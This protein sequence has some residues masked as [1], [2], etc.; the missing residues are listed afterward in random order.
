VSLA[1]GWLFLTGLGCRD[2]L[3][4]ME[5]DNR[6]PYTIRLVLNGVSQRGTYPPSK[7]TMRHS[8][9]VFLDGGIQ[10]E[11]RKEPGGTV[12]FSRYYTGEPLNAAHDEGRFTVVVVDESKPTG[13][14]GDSRRRSRTT[15][16]TT[17]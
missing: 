5:I 10:V 2:N 9:G 14:Q 16:R 15:S 17:R 3:T 11:A 8:G 12:I 1:F 6:T 7:K 13:S 4:A